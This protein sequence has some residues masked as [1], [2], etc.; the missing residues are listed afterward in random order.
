MWTAIWSP[1]KSALKAR[2]DQGVDF[3]RLALDQNGFEG[4]NAQPV[5]RGS[6]VQHDGMVL[7]DLFQDV[8]NDGILP[9]HDLF[10][11]LNCAA[12]AAQFQPLIDEGLEKLQ[13]HFLGQSALVK[14]QFRTD[15]DDR[16]A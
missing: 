15:D 12:L 2:A 14:L 7:N 8:P 11:G 10:S 6:A 3:D 16:T 4:L 1:S 5:K 9:L 13:G